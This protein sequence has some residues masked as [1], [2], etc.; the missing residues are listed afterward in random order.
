MIQ[1]NARQFCCVSVNRFQCPPICAVRSPTTLEEKGTCCGAGSNPVTA[2][3]KE[4][5]NSIQEPRCCTQLREVMM[6]S[7]FPLPRGSFYCLQNGKGQGSASRSTRPKSSHFARGLVMQGTVCCRCATSAHRVSVAPHVRC[8][9]KAAAIVACCCWYLFCQH[10]RPSKA[11]Y[12]SRFCLYVQK[13]T[14]NPRS[15]ELRTQKLKFQ[16][17]RT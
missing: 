6:G 5:W 13:L 12:V 11:V 2:P 7:V 15:V 4:V 10:L 9:C 1:C 16:L 17:L 3:W 8:Q 14:P